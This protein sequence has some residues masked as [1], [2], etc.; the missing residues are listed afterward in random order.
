MEPEA[1]A[2]QRHHPVPPSPPKAELVH[3]APPRQHPGVAVD[4]TVAPGPALHT[5]SREDLIASARRAAIAASQK[6]PQRPEPVAKETTAQA[7]LPTAAAT[8]SPSMFDGLNSRMLVTLG[9]IMLAAAGLGMLWVKVMRKPAPMVKIERTSLP[10]MVD[11]APD[12]SAQSATPAPA[13]PQNAPK[14]EPKAPDTANPGKASE[15]TPDTAT[16][17][18]AA[19]AELPVEPKPL[20]KT[21]VPVKVETASLGSNSSDQSQLPAA[22]GPLSLRTAAQAGD[23]QASYAIGN[24]FLTG[25]GVTRDPQKAK[26]WLERAAAGGLPAAEF[27]LGILAEKGDA[28]LAPDRAAAQIWYNKGAEHGYVQAMHNLA[29]LYSAQ[30]GGTPNYAMAAKWF[31]QAA[32]Y[33]LKDSQYNIA[34]LYE[35]GLGVKK[36]LGAAYKWYAIAASHGDTEAGKRRDALRTQVPPGT[37]AMLDKEIKSWHPKLQDRDAETGTMLGTAAIPAAAAGT[38][39]PATSMAPDAA[40]VSMNPASHVGDVQKML[41]NLGY[42]PGTLDGTMTEQ[43]RAAIRTFELRSGMAETGEISDALIDKLKSLGG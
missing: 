6:A 7:G 42:D 3:Q 31:E 37:L 35:N 26:F 32:V 13:K 4:D 22:I 10:A 9:M 15:L 1:P 36:D 5:L 2:H 38:A 21:E 43:T 33:G 39:V 16:E 23:A 18:A 25:K 20:A 34:V 17:S 27:K 29:V 41:S 14:T 11:D 8:H 40:P 24:R 19:A 12:A 30:D 28:G